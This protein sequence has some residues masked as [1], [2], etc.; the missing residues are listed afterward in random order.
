MRSRGSIT[1]Y[2]SIIIVGVVLVINVVSES[3]RI[4]MIQ[5]INSGYSNMAMESV[6]A[7]YGKQIYD[8]Y[9]ILLV[10][11][12]EPI[13]VQLEKYI[14]ANIN[15]ADLNLMGTNLLNTTL[16]DIEIDGV[17]Y[18]TNGGEEKFANQIVSYMKY[19][20]AIN[21]AEKLVQ[22][23]ND[24]NSGDYENNDV[25]YM[26]EENNEL[27]ELVKEI[28]IQIKDIKDIGDLLEKLSV[29]SQKFQEV[30]S[31]LESCND[32]DTGEAFLE[33]YRELIEL[34]DKEA[35]DIDA[36]ISLIKKYEGKKEQFLQRNGYTADA[37][38]Y[39]DDN[40]EELEK[41]KD[42]IEKN[43][44][45][46]VS[47][48]SEINSENLSI[49]LESIQKIETIEKKLKSL[50][51]NRI[52]KE[53]EKNH[54]IYE[55]AKNLLN[56]G[57]LSLVIDDT[58]KLSNSAVN[59]SNLPTSKVKNKDVKIMESLQNKAMVTLYADM[60][61]GNY[62]SKKAGTYLSYELEYII[63]G[64]DNDKENLT[65]TIEKLVLF[66]NGIDMAYLLT[67]AKKM[68]E[69]SAIA[70]SAASV[71]CMPFLE[72]VIKG[73]LV[74][75]WSLAEAVSDVKALLKGNNIVLVKTQKNWKTS[76]ANL[77]QSSGGGDNKGLDYATYC[78][79]LILFQNNNDCLFRIMDLMQINIQKRY[80]TQFDLSECFQGA[81]VV[82][83]YNTEPLFSSMPWSLVM[84]NGNVSP[85]SYEIKCSKSY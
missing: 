25:G 60:K 17:S 34:I 33:V 83:K 40:L 42:N 18:V 3:S 73:V 7:G 47:D 24:I 31:D 65:N 67:D 38:D 55:S 84:L 78:Q 43:K 2:I 81:E 27:Q 56:N 82:F 16:A 39:I 77:L 85:Y 22:K 29:V 62:I 36:T 49:A 8:D 66:R 76:I 48:F 58:S 10:W 63:G 15:M 74:E 35:V 26:A 20:G 61:F 52:T 75:A 23:I 37:G 70:L 5:T 13:D 51:V 57:I 71:M 12:K 32:K 21:I 28:D 50:K 30:K 45:L 80:N 44:E 64:R 53:D 1:V 41:V 68:G 11:E 69:I 72:P 59:D 6:L 79:I 14:Q 46:K 9:G 4:N 54:S 19:A